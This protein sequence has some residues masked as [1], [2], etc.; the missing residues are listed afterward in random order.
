MTSFSWLQVR[1]QHC[2]EVTHFVYT[3][4]MAASKV[5]RNCYLK[6]I[7]NLSFQPKLHS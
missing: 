4:K 2:R 6:R 7:G 1:F 5:T 3:G